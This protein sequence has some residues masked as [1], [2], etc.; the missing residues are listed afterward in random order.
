MTY[1]ISDRI[2]DPEVIADLRRRGDSELD[3]SRTRPF[4]WVRPVIVE[5]WPCAGC[6]VLVGMTRD[7]IDLHAMFN[8]LLV[9][10]RG[11]TPITRRAQCATC[12]DGAPKRW[13]L[14]LV[15]GG[16]DGQS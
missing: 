2:S 15:P 12:R 3:S 16:D 9:D 11:D 1:R 10:E 7:A 5:E 6:G 4:G 8:R 14:R 13:P